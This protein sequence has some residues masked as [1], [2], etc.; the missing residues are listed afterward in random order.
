[1]TKE[2]YHEK[3]SARRTRPGENGCGVKAKTS[4][5]RKAKKTRRNENPSNLP[6]RGVKR[7]GEG[8][9]EERVREMGAKKER[10]LSFS[11]VHPE[12][13]QVT[14]KGKEDENGKGKRRY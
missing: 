10:L 3:T 8:E 1:V 4:C 7:G 6:P 5:G 13:Q 14:E 12:T 9:K 2:P 11:K